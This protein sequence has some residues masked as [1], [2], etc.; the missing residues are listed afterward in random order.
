MSFRTEAASAPGT[1]PAARR[2]R[3]RLAL[4][5]LPFCAAA[6]WLLGFTVVP[7]LGDAI[8]IRGWQ[9]GDA[10]LTGAGVRVTAGRDGSRH[11][12]WATYTYE[13]AGR[14]HTGDRVALDR[15]GHGNDA[16][17]QRLGRRLERALERGEPVRVW[18][19]PADP[20][21]ALLNRDV[22][23]G[24]LA[25]NFC[26][27]TLAGSAGLTLLWLAVA[28]RRRAPLVA[29]SPWLSRP[30]WAGPVIGSGAKTKRVLAWSFAGA[31]ALAA[32]PIALP[33]VRGALGSREPAVLGF[34]LP[35]AAAGLLFRALREM[36]AWRRLERT[37][38]R[39]DPWPGAIGGQVGAIL[40][41]GVP[42][43]P[44]HRFRAALACV[45]SRMTGSGDNRRRTETVVWRAEL[46]ARA[47]RSAV[48]TRVEML[49]DVEDGLPASE[50]G[51][52]RI[53]HFWRL[54]V[55]A[56]LPGGDFARDYEI[57]VFPT[58]ERART[59][60]RGRP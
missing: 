50:P 45:K 47:V 30:E 7:W 29:G 33:A 49:F 23:W 18:I 10:W 12:A 21:Q 5:A 53:C 28:P 48:G 40:E 4:A 22:H 37:S 26:A 16:F 42:F 52:A 44:A 36:V 3:T 32:A 34:L 15:F 27:G 8:A 13:Y 17:Q 51:H 58:G 9:A 46:D 54:S 57:P 19:D 1:A 38:L 41:L 20:T 60:D 31:L 59:L 11:R 6:V 2:R 35:L 39:L 24:R 56:R 14:T 25:L 43:D 55:H